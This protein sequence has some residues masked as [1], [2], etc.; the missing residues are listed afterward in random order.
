[1]NKVGPIAKIYEAYTAIAD[2]RVVFSADDNMAT[3][4]SSDGNKTYM[5]RWRDNVY[6]SD[7]NATYWQ[8]YPGYP[9]IAVL[10]KQGK[11]TLDE[12]TAAE[13]TKVNWHALNKQYKR[14]YD[15]AVE[16]V[17]LER[18]LNEEKINAAA[19]AVLQQLQD[20]DIILKRN[21]EL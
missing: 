6:S 5:V 4:S 2:D 20:L 16:A 15:K 1:M 18:N 8:G 13:F 10:M 17:I 11:L 3:V 12:E 9:V 19:E 21:C 7:D 14:D